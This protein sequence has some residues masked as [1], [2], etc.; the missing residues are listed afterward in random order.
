M[1]AF[2]LKNLRCDQSNIHV[3]FLDVTL[4]FSKPV[5]A[6]VNACRDTRRNLFYIFQ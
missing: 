3:L 2:L 4:T 6:Y 5:F 1:S